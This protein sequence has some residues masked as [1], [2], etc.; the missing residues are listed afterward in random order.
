MLK[1]AE[2]PVKI[3]SDSASW[4]MTWPS[5]LLVCPSGVGVARVAFVLGWFHS[6]VVGRTRSSG[7]VMARVEKGL[8]GFHSAVGRPLGRVGW[9]CPSGN[10]SWMLPL[11]LFTLTRSSGISLGRVAFVPQSQLRQLVS[12]F[13]KLRFGRF[14]LRCRPLTAHYQILQRSTSIGWISRLSFALENDYFLHNFN[15]KTQIKTQMKL[16]NVRVNQALNHH[17]IKTFKHIY[18]IQFHTNQI[19][20]AYLFFK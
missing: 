2:K 20:G 6:A 14:F 4:D 13:F 19:E 3:L 1:N 12:F 8:E 17:Q 7:V 5:H 15:S 11:G 18:P 10:W 16:A 9:W